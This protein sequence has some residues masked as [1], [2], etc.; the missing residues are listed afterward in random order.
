VGGERPRCYFCPKAAAV[1]KLVLALML[2]QLG[3]LH[4]VAASE[5]AIDTA[6]S[7]ITIHVGK[8]GLFSAAGHEHEVKAPIE[9][10]AI[11][12]SDPGRVW[13]KVKASTLTVQP[14]A[15][16]A[17]VQ[18]TM[19]ATVLESDRYPEV[20]FESTSVRRL[21]RD[22]WMVTGNLTLHG[23]T[24]AVTTEVHRSNNEYQGQAKIKQTQFGI[25][26]VRVAG[27]TVK[28][29]DE[30]TIDFDIREK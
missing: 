4:T 18:S 15:D 1:K 29:K 20:R 23:S 2:C 26:P 12:D 8:A 3:S 16:Q 30:L 5:R 13:F 11:D 24:K 14:E 27:G 19:Q 9:E 17:A 21:D 6:H 28:V 10:G 25:Q 7:T 22:R